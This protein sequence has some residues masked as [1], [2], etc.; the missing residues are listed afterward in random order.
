MNSLI[1]IIVPV[2]NSEK[3]LDKC[4]EC[5]VGQTY[6]NLEIILVDDGSTDSS[7]VICK[8][9][10]KSDSRIKIIEKKNEGAG[11]ARNAGLSHASGELIMFIDSDDWIELEMLEHLH[12]LM[13][14]H[15]ADLAVC[16][17]FIENPD[18]SNRVC[19]SMQLDQSPFETEK[20][21]KCIYLLDSQGKLAYLWNR[22]YRRSIIQENNLKFDNF[23][24]TGQDLDFNLKYLYHVRKCVI[25]DEPYYH[26]IKHGTGSLCARYKKNL[27]AI[28]SELSR[29]RYEIYRKFGMLEDEN[30]FHLYAKTHVEYLATC[31][32]NMFRQNT[33]LSRTEKRD[34]LAEIFRDEKLKAYIDSY[35][36]SSGIQKLYKKLV[37]LNRADVAL[38]VYSM[39][40][41]VRNNHSEVYE[42]IK[43]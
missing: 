11:A 3:Y 42:K 4:L 22:M 17:Y 8:K 33:C 30:L 40:F 6:S 36:P 25:S 23:F 7:L 43:K 2:Y 34:Q 21:Q 5:L 28:V 24:T 38:V 13:M 14:E 32:P 26:Y 37:K 20:V 31:I 9:F 27:Y 1:S 16:N 35:H 10:Q 15:R 12:G 29:R 18:G 41:W 39:L 19:Y